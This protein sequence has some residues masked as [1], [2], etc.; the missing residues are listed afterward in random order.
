MRSFADV[1]RWQQA[2]LLEILTMGGWISTARL[3][4]GNKQDSMD[5]QDLRAQGFLNLKLAPTLD[6]LC[7]DDG[8]DNEDWSLCLGDEDEYEEDDDALVLGQR[9]RSRPCDWVYDESKSVLENRRPGFFQSL[10]RF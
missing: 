4:W 10:F 5:Y 8:D 1:K 2:R 6:E 9:L 3:P 7:W